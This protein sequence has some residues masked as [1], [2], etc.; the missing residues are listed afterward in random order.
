MY[1]EFRVMRCFER[2]HTH[3]ICVYKSINLIKPGIVLK[4]Y[5]ND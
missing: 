1:A 3:N 5:V 4:M 2:F